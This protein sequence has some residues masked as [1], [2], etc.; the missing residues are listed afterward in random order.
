MTNA[1][2]AFQTPSVAAAFAAFP[3]A[4]R[5]HLLDLRRLILETAA[6]TPGVGAL[7]EVLKWGQPAYLTAQSKSGSTIRLGVPKTGGVAIY[8]HCQT[9]LISDFRAILPDAF[10]YEGNRAI[11]LDTGEALQED[12]LCMF[13]ASAL[14]YHLRKRVS[15]KSLSEV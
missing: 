12:R 15:G 3:D 10:R 1:D 4:A 14:T 9:T 2:P 5:P 11:L 6:Q 13:I 7:Q 8:T